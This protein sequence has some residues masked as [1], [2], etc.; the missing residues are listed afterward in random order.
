M[1]F[2]AYNYEN[3]PISIVN[4]KSIE[5]AHAYWHGANITVHSSKSLDDF[6]PLEENFTGVYPILKTTEKSL[7]EFGQNPR[8]VIIVKK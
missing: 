8:K 3:I 6:I 5:I 7:S 1:I 2:I 4:A